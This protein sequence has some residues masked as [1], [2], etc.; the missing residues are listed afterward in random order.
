MWINCD[1]IQKL[2][3]QCYKM[4]HAICA[5]KNEEQYYLSLMN[6]KYW[7]MTPYTRIMHNKLSIFFTF[8]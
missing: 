7:K 2:N 8:G 5:S 4:I 3:M 1:S 6:L